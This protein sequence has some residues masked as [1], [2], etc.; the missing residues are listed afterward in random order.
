MT[1][2]FFR[3]GRCCSLKSETGSYLSALTYLKTAHTRKTNAVFGKVTATQGM[4]Y[5][6][7]QRTAQY[8]STAAAPAVLVNFSIFI[9]YYLL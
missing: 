1:F 4:F 9:T 7:L 6:P 5:S 8:I 2:L 3:Q